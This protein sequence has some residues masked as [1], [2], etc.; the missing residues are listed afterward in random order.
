M[1]TYVNA[2][3][4]GNWFYIHRKSIMLV[5][6]INE[7]P[8]DMASRV[9]AQLKGHEDFVSSNCQALK[10]WDALCEKYNND[11][12][13]CLE[14]LI[15]NEEPDENIKKTYPRDDSKCYILE[16]SVHMQ[17]LYFEEGV[18]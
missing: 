6:Y 4:E 13:V 15:W 7:E 10:D 14:D 12:E 16:D 8:I 5:S 9:Y 18:R 3:M 17:R 1:M 11:D 2:A